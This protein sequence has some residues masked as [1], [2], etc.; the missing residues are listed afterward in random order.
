[1]IKLVN[2]LNMKILNSLFLIAFVFSHLLYSQENPGEISDPRGAIIIADMKGAVTVTNNMTGATLPAASVQPGKILFDG[3]TIKTTGKDS[4]IVLLL[5]N[6]TVTTL[7]ADSVLNIKKFT[8][9]KFDP[10]ATKLS[11]P[12]VSQVLGNAHRPEYR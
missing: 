12:K 7:K 10:G 8:Q 6:G 4:S 1:M 2:I 3:H 9:A 11:E 5:S